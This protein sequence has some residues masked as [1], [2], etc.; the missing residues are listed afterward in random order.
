MYTGEAAMMILNSGFSV[1]IAAFVLVRMECEIKKLTAAIEQL[2]R[3][4]VCTGGK[5]DNES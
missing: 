1:G 5:K 2:K 4:Q 3:C